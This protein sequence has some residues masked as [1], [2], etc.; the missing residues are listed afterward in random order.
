MRKYRLILV[1]AVSVLCTSS[2]YAGE[3]GN[4]RY[5]HSSTNIRAERSAKSKVV[6]RLKPG[7]E[8]KVDFQKSDWVAVFSPRETE[9]DLATARGYVY[10][11]L[12]KIKPLKMKPAKPITRPKSS[13]IQILPKFKPKGI[14][15][16]SPFQ[17]EE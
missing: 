7:E 13:K 8:I 15:E 9:R 10:V 1:A 5:V 16:L 11:P 6:A 2:S 14:S 3:W 17:K 12:L 4:I